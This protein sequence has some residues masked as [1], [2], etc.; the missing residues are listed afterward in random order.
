M[1]GTQH[2]HFLLTAILSRVLSSTQPWTSLSS[3]CHFF[4]KSL[5]WDKAQG[6]GLS[7]PVSNDEEEKGGLEQH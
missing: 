4:P 6:Q 1:V 2:H 7:A 5:L 3:G